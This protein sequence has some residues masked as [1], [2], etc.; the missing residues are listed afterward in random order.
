MRKS[1][2]VIFICLP[3]FLF[4]ACGDVKTINIWTDRPEFALYGDYFN[5][6]QNQYKV[7]IQYF[8][9]PAE[10]LISSSGEY[11]DIVV[12]SWL[13]SRVTSAHFR[14]LNSLL[15]EKK[16]PNENFYPHL[17]ELG[18][19]DSNH[20][21]LPVSFNLPALIFAEDNGS[22]LSNSFTIDFDEIKKLSSD[23]NV[24]S[25][26]SYTR[27]GFSPMW[28]EDFL[29]L[30]ANLFGASFREAET[31]SNM[32]FAQG[33]THLAW[34]G[35]ALAGSM[36]FI[37]SW[38]QEINTGSQMEEDFT[39]KYFFEPPARLIQSGRILFSYM[40][41]SVLFTLSEENKNSLDFR[42]IMEQ[43][44]IPIIEDAVFL[45]IPK[46]AKSPRAA[47]AFV[48]WFFSQESQKQLLE[49]SKANRINET[50]FGICGGFSS[51]A[52]VTEQ[53]FPLYYPTLLGRMPPEEYLVPP[54]LFP[55]NWA[56]IKERVVLPYL[57]DRAR[58]NSAED[59]ESLEK[60]LSEWLRLNR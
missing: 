33:V 14:S 2:S 51:V 30:T 12:A 10:K 8:E 42:W 47:K 4:F 46:K 11:P 45:G 44:K 19:I 23:F 34:D 37:N 13:K 27:M 15:G 28:N 54:N 3:A 38:T 25:R 53:I 1:F 17:L 9:Y 48:R 36:D 22:K 52:P 56:V 32:W 7:T 16:I 29:F 50:V 49:F 26:G 43:N 24:I 20:H 58:K 41:S 18:R 6:V 59:S 39:F 31:V 21:L 60:R 35:A 40:K 5:T 57:R 55:E